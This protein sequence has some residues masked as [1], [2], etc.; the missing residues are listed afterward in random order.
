MVNKSIARFKN[1]VEGIEGFKNQLS[2]I[3]ERMLS[4]ATKKAQGNTHA[5]L[6]D[7]ISTAYEKGLYSDFSITCKGQVFQVHR[8]ILGSQSSY[9]ATLF[10]SGFKVRTP[11]KVYI[12][13]SH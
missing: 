8:L 2:A 7:E 13:T 11:Q 4:G 9:F 5:H 3:D 12:C 10:K 6:L 1:P